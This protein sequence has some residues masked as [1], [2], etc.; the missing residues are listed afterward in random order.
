M[1]GLQGGG[2][3]R[4]RP[5]SRSLWKA[6]RGGGWGASPL[7]PSWPVP[8][9]GARLRPPQRSLPDSWGA[10]EK[11]L[12]QVPDGVMRDMVNAKTEIRGNVGMRA[13]LPKE[14]AKL[15]LQG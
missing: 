6:P 2:E 13:V 15:A 3:P 10:G 12:S 11:D 8:S 1:N 14:T 7:T 9:A 5:V 4:V